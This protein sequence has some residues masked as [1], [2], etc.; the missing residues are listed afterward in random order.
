MNFA[1]HLYNTA[2]KKTEPLNP[3]QPGKLGLYLCGATVSGPAHIGHVRAAVAFDVLIRWAKRCGMEVT[4]IRNIT[5]ID[6]KILAKSAQ[7]GQ[8]WWAW[9]ARWERDFDTAYQK[10]GV[11]PPTYEPRA[12]AHILDQIELIERLVQR[13]HAYSDGQGNVYFSVTSLPEYGA[14]TR[15]KIE[16]LA[17]TEDESQIETSVEAG[18]RDPRDFALWKAAK[19]NEPTSASWDSPWGRGRPGWH[20]EC[21][22]MSRRYLGNEFD[23]HGGGIDLRF[24]HHENE[25][26]QSRAAGWKFVN[27]W[28]HNAWV[29][30]KGEKM[31]KS[32][33]NGLLVNEIATGY[34]AAPLRIALGTVHYRSTIEWDS[35]TFENAEKLWQK[36]STFTL[37]AAAQAPTIAEAD[38]LTLSKIDLPSEFVEG[39]N[40]DLNLSVALAQIHA[41]LKQATASLNGGKIEQLTEQTLTLRAM[42]DVL[43]LDP[44]HPHWIES[45]SHYGGGLAV[46]D[47]ATEALGVLVENVL[48]ERAQARAEKNWER[49]D[50]LRDLLKDAG[51]IVEDGANGA[52]WHLK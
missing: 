43:G 19:P 29:T 6:D 20:L 27:H 26:A 5:D 14:L 28:M 36:L 38:S 47:T 46:S 13:S 45:A 37:K 22:A 10:L 24:P 34:G 12:T 44:L 40:D 9:A 23:V 35:T 3:V 33:G 8:P 41:V 2:T 15:Q 16:E 39:M 25:L 30:A 32:L 11:I 48:E 31:S 1:L 21:S 52:N 49:A 51:V 7:A 4:Y 17:S 42:L 50:K 18:K